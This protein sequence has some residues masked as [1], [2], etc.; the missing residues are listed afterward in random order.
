MR[1]AFAMLLCV[2]G[3]ATCGYGIYCIVQTYHL[4]GT[5]QYLTSPYQKQILI[6]GAVLFF[7]NIALSA[8]KNKR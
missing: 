6:V 5:P 1:R 7:L 3:L 2:V 8:L 4:I